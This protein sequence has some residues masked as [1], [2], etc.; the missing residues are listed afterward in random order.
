MTGIRPGL[1]LLQGAAGPQPPQ[2]IQGNVHA[3][4][5]SFNDTLK[6]EFPNWQTGY[7]WNV[8]DW[9][10]CHGA[11]LPAAG[12]ECLLLIDDRRN[13]RCVWWD[14]IYAPPSATGTA[15]GDLS[16]SFPNPTVAKVQGRAIDSSAPSSGNGL[17][18]TG[19]AWTPT[20]VLEAANNLSDV[21]SASTAR[22]N[23]GLGSAATQP[24][25]LFPNLPSGVNNQILWGSVNS[26][27]SITSG[28]SGGFSVSLPGGT[29]VQKIAF[30]T[31]FANTGYALIPTA[32][33]GYIDIPAGTKN[34]TDCE[35]AT[36]NSS[37]TATALGFNF[38]AI[39]AV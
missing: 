39:G 3:A 24:Q 12:A 15:G 20:A 6:V 10:A 31:A 22:T 5:A 30:T 11:T 14:G 32:F 17:V 28:S 4:P 2:I 23:L 29:G 37:G 13:L 9:P 1:A 16:G 7:F 36:F 27:A 18:W 21:S 25:N 34:T 19:A 38:I 33:A 35:I 8:T 26:A